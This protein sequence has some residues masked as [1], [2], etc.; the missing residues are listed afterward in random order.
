MTLHNA[1]II[2]VLVREVRERHKEKALVAVIIISDFLLL[3]YCECFMQIT[4]R[5]L[6]LS[7]FD[8]IRRN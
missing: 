7:D 4:A 6:N 1:H 8:Y 5:D 3:R 2:A